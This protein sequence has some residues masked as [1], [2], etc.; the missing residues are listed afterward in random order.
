MVQ[1]LLM[2]QVLF[3]HDSKVE[4]LFYGALSGSVPSLFVSNYYFCLEL[5]PVQDDLQH[6]FARKTDEADSFIVLA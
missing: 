3:T 2:F 4:D 5:K 1:I 6:D